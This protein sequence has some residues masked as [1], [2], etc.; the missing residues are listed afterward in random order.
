MIVG[1]EA[2]DDPVSLVASDVVDTPEAS[3]TLGRRNLCGGALYWRF[4]PNLQCP[5]QLSELLWMV[6]KRS[7]WLGGWFG[8]LKPY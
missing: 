4:P 3:E 6:E 2:L 1:E 5:Q 8:V 7:D